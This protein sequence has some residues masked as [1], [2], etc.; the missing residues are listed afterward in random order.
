MVKPSASM[1]AISAIRFPFTRRN[2][3][4]SFLIVSR[5]LTA[6]QIRV[7]EASSLLDVAP[8]ILGLLG[9]ALPS[10]YQRE[11]LLTP[12]LAWSPFQEKATFNSDSF[13]DL[14]SEQRW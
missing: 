5:G 4:V 13:W 1:K 7:Q 9:L 12:R 2:V 11:S 14:H 10:S 6:R 8:T 3:H